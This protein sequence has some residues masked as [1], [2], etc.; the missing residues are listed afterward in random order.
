M[1]I[2]RG[3]ISPPNRTESR[4]FL[5]GD[6]IVS[7]TTIFLWLRTQELITS[8]HYGLPYVPARERTDLFPLAISPE[9]PLFS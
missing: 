5:E 9:I 4:G 8:F 6:N 1:F 2:L 3:P 7:G